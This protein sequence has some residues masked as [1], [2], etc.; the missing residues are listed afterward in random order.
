VPLVFELA[1]QAAVDH[2]GARGEAA[3]ERLHRLLV[4]AEDDRAARWLQI[5]LANA[6]HFGAEVWIGAMK[7]LSDAVRPHP[8]CV[9]RALNR[10]AAD[11]NSTPYQQR[12]GQRLLRPDVAEGDALFAIAGHLHQLAFDGD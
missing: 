12:V 7:P 8:A 10:A 2:H 4:D 6:L 11:G 5:Q 9:Q 3:E 1:A